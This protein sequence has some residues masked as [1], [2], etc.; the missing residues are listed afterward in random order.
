MSKILV[1]EDTDA[2]REEIVTFLLLADYTVYEATNGI[3]GIEKANKFLPD[4]IVSDILMPLCD[5]Y[6]MLREL[7]KSSV[8]ENIPLIFLTAKMEKT[9]IRKGMNLGA[10]DYLTKPLKPSDLLTSINNKLLKHEKLQ[11][12]LTT[13]KLN[14]SSGL[15]HE[16]RTPL[17]GILG[18][19]EILRDQINDLSQNE[20][21]EYSNHIYQGGKRLQALVENYILYSKLLFD[22]LNGFKSEKKADTLMVK[23]VAE[24]T[25]K[26]IATSSFRIKDVIS[27]INDFGI[28]I[29][30]EDFEKI[31]SEL[32]NN[33]IK[34]STTGQKIEVNAGIDNSLGFLTIRNEGVGMTESEIN[35]IG[36]FTQFNRDKMEQQ[37]IGL[38]LSIVKLMVNKY[39]GKIKFTSKKD[40]FFEVQISFPINNI[41]T[42]LSNSHLKY[43]Q[44]KS[45]YFI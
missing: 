35:K 44:N 21:V 20:I 37:G 8:T 31:V 25:I 2:I 13:L 41:S 34:F 19:S 5:G 38:G 42:K 15:P 45:D 29:N 14:L 12:K 24:N 11:K 10:D 40:E 43:I 27:N 9:D 1:V 17:N 33:A 18:F 39:S 3:E 23:K 22:S 32:I 6:Q 26:K 36:G 7:R 30:K 4:L 16:F 28:E